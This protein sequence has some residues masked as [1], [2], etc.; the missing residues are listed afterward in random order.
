MRS[1]LSVKAKGLND[2]VPEHGRGAHKHRE[3]PD[4]CNQGADNGLVV[5]RDLLADLSEIG[6]N[7]SR[8][9]G[10]KRHIATVCE[11]QSHGF[12]GRV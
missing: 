4:C 8:K 2:C 1:A 10:Q 3:K 11:R 7:R 12:G 5:L 9:M 6:A